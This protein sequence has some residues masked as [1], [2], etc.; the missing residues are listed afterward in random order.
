MMIVPEQKMMRLKH[1]C[2]EST[3]IHP[4]LEVENFKI[5]FSRLFLRSIYICV[6]YSRYSS[7]G[8]SITTN[9]RML[10]GPFSNGKRRLPL[11]RQFA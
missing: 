2:L 11:S 3:L 9:I 1:M 10:A 4:C 6:E 8:Q 7:L 5:L